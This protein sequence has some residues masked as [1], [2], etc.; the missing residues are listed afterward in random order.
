LNSKITEIYF[1]F[2]SDNK[3]SAVIYKT[4]AQGY[5]G[6]VISLVCIAA[7][8]KIVNVKMVEA[9]KETP[10]KGD[11]LFNHD[12]SIAN[13]SVDNY[14]PE[15]L[16]GSTVTANAVVGGIH[17]A[18]AHFKSIAHTLGGISND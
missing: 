5:G 13:E 7:D 6:A 4:K 1:A 10:G 18:V 16:A 11:K 9:G 17:A 8:G 3:L 2:G 12:F 14:S 15:I